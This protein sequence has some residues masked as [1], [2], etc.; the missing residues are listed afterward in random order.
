MLDQYS[1]LPNQA[2]AVIK[3]IAYL[4]DVSIYYAE[5][6]TGKRVKFTLPNVLALAEQPLTWEQTVV[7]G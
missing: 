5:L 1:G 3:D 6:E 4:G 7:L 2:R